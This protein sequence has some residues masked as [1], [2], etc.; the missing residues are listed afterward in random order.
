MHKFYR[1]IFYS[2]LAGCFFTFIGYFGTRLLIAT[3]NKTE[4][5]YSVLDITCAISI[6]IITSMAFYFILNLK[7]KNKAN[8]SFEIKRW[9]IFM[10]LLYTSL[11]VFLALFPGHYPYDSSDM[12]QIFQSGE[13][14]T[15]YSPLITFIIGLF[16]SVGKNIGS[17]QLGH[18]TL[19]ILQCLFVNIVLTEIIYYCSNKLKQ[20]SF[21]IFS[22][23]FFIIHPLVQVLI[24]RSGQDTIFGGL[25]ALLCLEL[26]KIVEEEKYFDKK[27][28]FVYLF[29]LIFLMCATRN[30]GF[31]A[32]LPAV[33]IGIFVVKKGLRKKFLIAAITPLIAFLGYNNLLIKNIVSENESFYQETLSVPI[34]QIARAVYFH[35][36]NDFKQELATYFDL[37]YVNWSGGTMKWEEYPEN[38]GISDPY[39]NCLRTE[40]IEKD[41][42]KFFELWAKIGAKYSKEYAEAPA[43]LALGLYHPY[44]DYP[45]GKNNFQWHLYVDS[46]GGI[47]EKNELE[48]KSLIPPLY[49]LID[50]LIHNQAWSKVPILH[51]LWGAPFTTYL[52]LLLILFVLYKKQYKYL[53]PVMLIFGLLI[54]IFLSPVM[55]FRYIFPAVLCTP[56]MVYIFKSVLK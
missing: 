3:M 17:I 24:V 20:K 38:A 51:L 8:E 18:A 54:T 46:F 31:Y 33:I 30:N 22:T 43:V 41:P 5:V 56:I 27:R 1:H 36:D 34:M 13:Y 6:T 37:D 32:L 42:K 45:A 52:C 53:L 12:Y 49:S 10:P 26:L 28:R 44:L 50:Y 7:I 40:E 25:F 23:V 47:Y 19:I 9:Q 4:A 21:T 11:V 55:L 2:V 15:H 14:T 39:K 35:P 48:F 16:L 29:I